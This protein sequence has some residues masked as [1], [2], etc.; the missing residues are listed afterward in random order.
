M[1]GRR[2]YELRL[3]DRC[4]VEFSIDDTPFGPEVTVVDFDDDA[5]DLMPCGISLDADGV[6]TWL[7]TRSIPTNRKNAT[8][9][10]RSLGFELGDREALYRTSMGLSLNDS[11][12][13]VPRGFTGRFD[14]FNLYDNPFSEAIGALAVAREP[15]VA[16]LHGN[17]PELTTDGTLRKGWRIVNDV[18]TLYKGSTDGFVPGEPV[19]EYLASLIARDAGLDAVAY[20]IESWDGETCSTCENFA[21]KQVSYVPFAVATGETGLAGV[22]RWCVEMGAACLEDVCSMLV[23]DALVCNTDRHLTN[24]GVLRDNATGKAIGL[25]PI[26][27]NGRSLFPNVADDDEKQFML[28][29]SLRAP[30]FGGTSFLELAGRI[31]GE[32]QQEMLERVAS[33]GIVGNVL[34]GRRRVACLDAFVREQAK[35][36]AALPVVHHTELAKMLRASVPLRAKSSGEVRR[37]RP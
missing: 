2:Y 23:F 7:E 27:D 9:I 12:W 28:E 21:S 26:F 29:A 37:I 32:V 22:L 24:F 35:E 14:D 15:S 25:A 1:A 33:R 16:D 6:W 13:V 11:Y 8:Q 20:S 31:K 34:A 17:T 5:W 19:S 18:R 3:F 30:A 36:L 10:C 4:L